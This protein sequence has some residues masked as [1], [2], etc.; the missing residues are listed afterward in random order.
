MLAACVRRNSRQLGPL[1]R[2]AAPASL[3][4]AAGGCWSATPRSRAWQARRRSADGPSA[5]SRA[6]AATPTP[7]AQPT[8][9]AD[10]AGRQVAATSGAQGPDASETASAASPEARRTTTAAGDRRRP[11]AGLDQPR[12]AS[13]APLGGAESRARAARP[14]T[15]CLSHPARGG[16]EPAHRAEPEERDRGRR[17]PCRRSSQP[18]PGGELTPILAPFRRYTRAKTTGR[19]ASAD[20][21]GTLGAWRSELHRTRSISSAGAE[22]GSLSGRHR[23]AVAT[24]RRRSLRRRLSVT[25]GTLFA[26]FRRRASNS[27]STCRDCPRCSRSTSVGVGAGMSALIGM[28]ACG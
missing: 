14:A 27:M 7:E 18:S 21:W 19:Q 11:P 5:D 25:M 24:A 28:A 6:R 13:A 23:L 8:A 1:R 20:S 12:R 16:Y 3:G 4:R 15:R 26:A 17:R 2:G 22:G 9:V 10:H